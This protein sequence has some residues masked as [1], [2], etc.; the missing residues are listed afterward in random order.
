MP[1]QPPRE[2]IYSLKVPKEITTV[3][4]YF[5]LEEYELKFVKPA[6]KWVIV[7]PGI[8][9]ISID[10]RMIDLKNGDLKL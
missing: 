1:K 4:E 5:K 6:N 7:V 2:T 9:H 3:A 10:K 8:G